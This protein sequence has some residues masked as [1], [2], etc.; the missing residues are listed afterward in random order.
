M[1]TSDKQNM[2]VAVKRVYDLPAPYDGT[3][4]LVDRLWPRGVAKAGAKI[5]LW[6][7]EVAPSASLRNWFGHAPNRWSRFKRRY[8]NELRKN[9]RLI[10]DLVELAHGG[11]LTLV[12]SARDERHNNAVAL[13]EYL[14]ERN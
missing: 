1:N 7:K 4:I 13:K 5:D 3:R 8:W 6:L 9:E 14:L 2:S 10:E 11:R 12:F